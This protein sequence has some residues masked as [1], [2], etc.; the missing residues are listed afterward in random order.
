ML[1]LLAG[2]ALTLCTYNTWGKPGV[3]GTDQIHRFGLIGPAIRPYDIVNLQETFTD[4]WHQIEAA[5]GFPFQHH[6][7]NEDRLH[8]SGGLY[9]LSKFPIVRH[10]AVQFT[11]G[12]T[13]DRFAHKGVLFVR[14]QVPGLGRLDV[15]NTH[16]QAER[17][18]GAIRI[19][20]NE[21]LAAFV[22]AHDEGNPTLLMGDFNMLP[23]SPEHLDLVQRLHPIDA[24]ATAHPNDPGFTSTPANPNVERDDRPERIDYIHVLPGPRCKITVEDARLAFTDPVMSD[25]YGV[26]ARIRF[27]R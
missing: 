27:S 7:S 21:V 16:Y 2:I 10:D 19:H 15:Y 13:W 18:Y 22:K 26:T 9:S 11:Q 17:A 14:L 6:E 8:L 12:A 24:W 4:Q 5:S 3:L 23:G 1:P 20:D 25:H